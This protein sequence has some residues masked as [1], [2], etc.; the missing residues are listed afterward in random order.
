MPPL[1]MSKAAKIKRQKK[2]KEKWVKARKN[3]NVHYI[4]SFFLSKSQATLKR[5]RARRII[6][7]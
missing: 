4:L 3:K 2:E 7:F 5:G 6:L 1:F